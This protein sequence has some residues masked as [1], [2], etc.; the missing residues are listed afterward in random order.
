LVCCR[1][2]GTNLYLL[3]FPLLHIF[4]Q[5]MSMLPFATRTNM[6]EALKLSDTKLSDVDTFLATLLAEHDAQGVWAQL[7]NL[8]ITNVCLILW[9]EDNTVQAEGAGPTG[10]GGARALHNVALTPQDS[11]K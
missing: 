9:E 2:D 5:N 8:W 10:A 6:L 4:D 7:T 3:F 1:P 11:P